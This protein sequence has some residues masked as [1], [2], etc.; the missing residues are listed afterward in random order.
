M[1]SHRLVSAAFN[2]AL[3]RQSGA[4]DPHLS[5]PSLTSQHFL[6]KEALGQVPHSV[7]SFLCSAVHPAISTFSQIHY[8]WNQSTSNMG[9]TNYALCLTFRKT[10]WKYHVFLTWYMKLPPA[11]FGI[12]RTFPLLT[13]AIL[14]RRATSFALAELRIC[15]T[16]LQ[17]TG[18][19]LWEQSKLID[20]LHV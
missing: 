18:I 6:E 3:N 14:L 9:V 8:K 7:Q 16:V 2:C 19:M 1:V 12:Y 20:E 11:Y 10:P 5:T 15:F 17:R 13:T 4:L